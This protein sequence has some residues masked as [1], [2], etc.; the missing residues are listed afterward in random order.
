MA[1]EP[2]IVLEGAAG[3]KSNNSSEINNQLTEP[4]D[5]HQDTI[6]GENEL[7]T[8]SGPPPKG[9]RY[10]VEYRHESSGEVVHSIETDRLDLEPIDTD[11]GKIFDIVTTFSTPDKEFKLNTDSG[12]P[13]KRS[14]PRITDTRKTVKMH[15][16]SPAIIHALRTIVKYYPGQN[17]LGEVIV[18][19]EPFA[20]LVHYEKELDE[21]KERCRPSR[22]TNPVC[23]KERVA[24]H[25]INILQ[26]FLEHAIMS[27][28][29]L[30]RERNKKDMNTFDMLWLRLKP[31]TTTKFRLNGSG[32]SWIAGV[33]E[34]VRRYD[35]EMWDVGYW[36]LD[37]QGTYLGQRKQVMK[38]ARFEGERER[39]GEFPIIDDSAFEEPFHESVKDFIKRGEK[40]YNLLSTKCQYYS[41]TTYKPP[42]RKVGS[43]YFLFDNHFY[44]TPQA[45]QIR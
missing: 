36:T 2:E 5:E 1:Q 41:G 31:G 42:N 43:K 40:F 21:Y 35:F 13:D 15:I 37:Y 12:E 20:I 28:V 39:D 9:V 4:L 11:T 14:N 29:R 27:A 45:T 16:H 8:S 38:I 33:I 18:I 19:P 32:K 10:R 25:E 34:Y 24:Y 30:E 22:Q 6:L 44:P 7:F 26:E 3:E 17:L 23:S